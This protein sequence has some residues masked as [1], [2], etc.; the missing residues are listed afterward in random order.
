[1]KQFIRFDIFVLLTLFSLTAN[2]NDIKKENH[3]ERMEFYLEQTLWKFEDGNFIVYR[4]KKGSLDYVLFSK[5]PMESFITNVYKSDQN[6]EID[7]L[8]VI[9]SKNSNTYKFSKNKL[10]VLFIYKN[11]NICH[12]YIDISKD[13]WEN[14]AQTY[15]KSQKN[16]EQ[17]FTLYNFFKEKVNKCR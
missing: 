13:E 8:E 11:E 7:S 15:S 1:M 9:I 16:S 3:F 2:A 6:I 14:L 4:T 12:D 17:Y 10:L 5:V